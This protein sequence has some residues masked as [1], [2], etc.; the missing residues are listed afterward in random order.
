MKKIVYV[1]GC[2]GLIGSH[3]TRKCLSKGWHVIGVDKMTYAARPELISEFK[4]YGPNNFK[5]IHSDIN[6]L[7]NLYNCDYIINAAAE[8]HVDN[9]II[10]SDEFLHS[11]INGVK[12]LLELIR[13]KGLFKMPILLQFSTDEVY[14]D[15]K[16]GSHSESD[17]LKPSNP[18]C[19]HPDT[20]LYMNDGTTKKIS[21]VKI[22]DVVISYSFQTKKS[23]KAKIKNIF[24]YSANHLL[25]L[26]ISEI[27]DPIKCTHAHRFFIKRPK[28]Y[29]NNKLDNKQDFEKL[30]IIEI[31]ASNIKPGDWIMVNSELSH[32]PNITSISTDFA[33][34]LGYFCGDG[35]I[36]SIRSIKKNKIQKTIL[37]ADDKR[38]FVEYYNS[39]LNNKGCIYKHKTKNCW[40]SQTG[41]VE[42][43]H[44]IEK[45]GLNKKSNEKIIPPEIMNSS[46][47]VIGAFIGGLYDADG[48]I[49]NNK[50]S[51]CSYS[52]KFLYQ[53]SFLLRKFGIISTVDIKNKRVIISH[54]HSAIKFQK[55]IPTLKKITL[56]CK[57]SQMNC[58][59]GAVVWKTVSEIKTIEYNGFVYD[60]EVE[61]NH[62]FLLR[63]FI[64]THNSATKASGDM[65]TLAWARTFKVPYIIVRPTNNYGVGQ[66]VEKLIPKTIKYLNIGRKIP[67]HNKGTP[68]RKWLHADDT[69]EAIITIIESGVKNEIYN[70]SGDLEL[71]NIDVVRKI[72]KFMFNSDDI[73]KF[74]DFTY[75]RDGQDVRY[76]LDDTKLRNLGWSPEKNFDVE[77]PKIIKFYTDNFIW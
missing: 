5:F 61:N 57:K 73:N 8:T 41:D 63:N 45:M 2:L 72:I 11:N 43:I 16:N 10:S 70:I 30:P 52:S 4:S 58:N 13:Q 12:H 62:N 37:L 36:K 66:Y 44:K 56:S 26:T 55:I 17:L 54:T 19:L 59:V 32:T 47:D 60:I 42:S 75:S 21:D 67:L 38:N 27:K 49:A 40:Y 9:S 50:L 7:N 18:Y 3:I 6:D 28:R 74:C 15:I 20:Y 51:I 33:R 14:G 68:Y 35:Y 69:A 1:T 71:Q 23:E 25:E 22:G 39:F 76:S 31:E 53:L 29:K 46:L 65:L 77:L 34:F 48:S 24:K 64:I